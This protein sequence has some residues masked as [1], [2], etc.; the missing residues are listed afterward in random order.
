VQDRAQRPVTLQAD[1]REHRI[2]LDGCC[3]LLDRPAAMM[4]LDLPQAA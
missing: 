3:Y 1:S 2:A 4:Q